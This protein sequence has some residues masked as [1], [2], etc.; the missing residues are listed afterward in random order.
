MR[1]MHHRW[2]SQIAATTTHI[3]SC[4]AAA[5]TAATTTHAQFILRTTNNLYHVIGEGLG[6]SAGA[7]DCHATLL[8]QQD[9]IHHSFFEPLRPLLSFL[10][11]FLACLAASSSDSA[12]SILYSWSARKIMNGTRMRPATSDILSLM[13]W[14][15]ET[16]AIVLTCRKDSKGRAPEAAVQ[17]IHDTKI[18]A[19]R[20]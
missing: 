13:P 17:E 9:Y 14:C 10:A 19:C 16:F 20:Y 11:C 18:P 8:F 6:A 7:L 2:Q 4:I 15:F 3:A 5:T 1:P 12:F